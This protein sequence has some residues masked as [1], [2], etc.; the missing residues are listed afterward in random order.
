MRFPDELLCS[1]GRAF[2]RQLGTFTW[3]GGGDRGT[4]RRKTHIAMFVSRLH[5]FLS[6]FFQSSTPLHITVHL[7][8]GGICHIRE[9]ASLFLLFHFAGRPATAPLA[10]LLD[11]LDD[12]QG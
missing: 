11:H 7:V 2:D 8:L 3:S 4:L 1:P 12:G 5:P 6:F 9:I 10:F